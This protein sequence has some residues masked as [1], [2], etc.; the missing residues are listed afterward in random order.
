MAWEVV[1]SV[2]QIYELAEK[3]DKP[4]HDA[5]NAIWAKISSNPH[6]HGTILTFETMKKDP[7]VRR[8]WTAVQQL[9]LPTAASVRIEYAEIKGPQAFLPWLA[10]FAFVVDWKPGTHLLLAAER[11]NRQGKCL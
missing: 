2:N 6:A 3:H 8:I 10:F 4:T 5:Y 9:T 1:E 7:N 11:V